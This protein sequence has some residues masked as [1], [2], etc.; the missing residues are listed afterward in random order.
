MI[1]RKGG[2]KGARE[3]R[4][5]RSKVDYCPTVTKHHRAPFNSVAARPLRKRISR[6]ADIPQV[7][8]IHIAAI[9]IEENFCFVRREGPL[10]DFAITRSEQLRSAAF[11]G[12]R[13]EMLPAV[14]LGCDH[15]LI[16]GSP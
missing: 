10:L 14:F 8:T 7:A 6:D 13:I 5:I 1:G 16:V 15:E 11:G 9:G 3:M 2:E 12:E 4:G